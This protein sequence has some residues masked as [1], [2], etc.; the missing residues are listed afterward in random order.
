MQ[1]TYLL[2]AGAFQ[3][4]INPVTKNTKPCITAVEGSSRNPSIKIAAKGTAEPELIC[5]SIILPVFGNRLARI[6][7]IFPPN[8]PPSDKAT[9]NRV[10]MVAVAL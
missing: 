1:E 6:S 2:V 4:M 5:D 8:N 7:P 9:L 3:E 10:K